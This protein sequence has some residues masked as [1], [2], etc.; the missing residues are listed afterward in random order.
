MKVSKELQDQV[1]AILYRADPEELAKMGV[2]KSVYAGEARQIIER[3]GEANSV[4]T[5]A[6]VVAD[7]FKTSFG[8]GY[9]GGS[10]ELTAMYSDDELKQY[11]APENFLAVATEIMAL[12]T[13]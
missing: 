6:A 1:T 9:F 4:E 3:L 12:T 8:C 13:A 11:Y 5:L 10:E 2:P 7:V